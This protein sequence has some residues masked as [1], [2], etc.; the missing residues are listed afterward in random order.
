MSVNKYVC[1]G[2]GAE[3]TTQG[4]LWNCNESAENID[5][6]GPGRENSTPSGGVVHGGTI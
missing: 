3:I 2:C 5:Y 1:R 4:M 6:I